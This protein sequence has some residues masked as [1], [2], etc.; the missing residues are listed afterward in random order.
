[1]KLLSIF[2][3]LS[4]QA[5]MGDW[6]PVEGKMLTPWGAKLDPAAAWAEYPR[7][8]LQRKDWTNLNGLWSY[9][10]AGKDSSKPETWA[11]EIL[12]PFC[13]E[14]SL[15]GVGKLIEPDQSLWY[16]RSL[17]VKP[18]AG[19]RTLLHFEAV[20]YETTVWVNDKEVGRHVGGNT[21]FTF[22]ITSALSS[23]DNKLVLRVFDATEGYQLHGKQSLKPRGIWCSR[24]SGIWQTVWMEQVPERS[25]E[26][27]DFTSNISEGKLGVKAALAGKA[28]AG[29]H[30]RVTASISGKQV[31]RIEGKNE[32]VS[33]V[34]AE[35]QLW[36]PE[37]PNLYDLDVELLDG[38]GKV[39]DTV[40]SYSALREVSKTRDAMGNLRITLNGKPIFLFGT[41]DQGWWPDG[42]LTPPSEEA[43]LSD[44]KF[45]KDTGFN[46]VRK[47]V[48][49]E[50]ARFYWDCDRL[51]IA[52]WQDQVS[53]SLGSYSEA[54]GIA[55][56]WTRMQPNPV[57][58]NW[59]PAAHDQW[60]LEYKRMVDH[61]RNSPS[62]LIW[63]PFN[64]AWGQHQTMEIGAMASAYDPTRLVSIASGG[65]FWPVGDIA[66]NHNY[67]DPSFPLRDDRFK[68]FIKV[69]GEMGGY[70]WPVT[71]HIEAPDKIMAYGAMPRSLDEWKI[72]YTQSVDKLT[73]LR[74]DGVSAAV[75]TQTTDM[76]NEVNGLLTYDRLPKVESSWL[77]Q[78]NDKFMATPDGPKIRTSPARPV[79]TEPTLEP[80]AIQN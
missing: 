15:S 21:P 72:R 18:V 56:K 54:A 77:K 8:Q 52:V 41:L 74:R 12:I 9:A 51:G 69:V 48:K 45:L 1:M 7:P 80:S 5:A 27:L 10:I 36:T 23:G 39:L 13:P 47:H 28:V 46:M 66:S 3:L 58:A 75:Y 49:V 79:Q 34:I 22:D 11:G 26:R 78:V 25:I 76:W 71:G 38:K 62:V 64:E 57:D 70:G 50:P 4:L 37:T 59:P 2:L 14:S 67:P 65:N 32:N 35:P 63:G 20:D 24:V 33:L 61:L 42:L 30:L 53:C 60:V 19:K 40:K 16:Q 17:S 43:M 31:G 29:E 68:D 6:K 44:L 55:P 73:A